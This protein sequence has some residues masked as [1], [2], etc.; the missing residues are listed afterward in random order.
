MIVYVRLWQ[1]TGNL[2]RVPCCIILAW[3]TIGLGPVILAHTLGMAEVSSTM[4]AIDLSRGATDRIPHIHDLS[5]I[6]ATSI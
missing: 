5:Y 2:F 1:V 4:H 3:M 6:E